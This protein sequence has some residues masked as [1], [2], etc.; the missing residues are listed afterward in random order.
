MLPRPEPSLKVRPGY[1][2]RLPLVGE[3][4]VQRSCDACGRLLTSTESNPDLWL[5]LVCGAL[6]EL[7]RS[8][9]ACTAILADWHARSASWRVRHVG[10]AGYASSEIAAQ[11]YDAA[12]DSTANRQPLAPLDGPRP[13][14]A[15]ACL[16]RSQLQA[17]SSETDDLYFRYRRSL[18]LHDFVRAMIPFEGAVGPACLVLQIDGLDSAWTAS[19]EERQALEA[20][21]FQILRCWIAHFVRSDVHKAR[22]RSK[23]SHLQGRLLEL[24]AEGQSERLIAETL[25][26]S[27]HTIHEHV[28][29]I[30]Q[31]LGV[32]NRMELR[33]LWLG[34][35]KPK[36]NR[37]EVPLDAPDNPT[38]HPS[39]PS[40]P[41]PDPQDE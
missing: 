27:R 38:V 15:P 6:S 3:T 16:T 23:L 17:R 39:L 31:T 7:F 32:S 21:A 34:R 28:K 2:R 26:R 29:I 10:I 30:Y 36:F 14:T 9:A 40:G 24:L 8:H 13:E 20:V 1:G 37:C 33:D 4:L 25:G 41:F 11:V 12:R 5:G 35:P 22:L 19:E 18:M